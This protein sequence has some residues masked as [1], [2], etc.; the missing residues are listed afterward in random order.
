L[1]KLLFSV[2]IIFGTF[3]VYSAVNTH[4]FMWSDTELIVENQSLNP[5]TKKSVLG[6]WRAPVDGIYSPVTY[7]LWAALTPFARDSQTGNLKP[8][9]FHTANLSVHI[10]NSVLVL[11]LLGF[12]F[13]GGFAPFV[14]AALFALHPLQVEPVALISSFAHLWATFFGLVALIA[15]LGYSRAQGAQSWKQKRPIFRYYF[16]TTAYIASILA[17]PAMV[18]LPFIAALLERLL[19][20]K[21]SL[22][23]PAKAVWP[24]MTWVVLG[25]PVAIAAL[26][27]Q[28]TAAISSQVDW[29]FRPMIAG[30][31]LAFYI[32]KLFVPLGIGP[33][34]GRS[35]AFLQQQWWG[36]LSW[37]TPFVLLVV[38]MFW[39]DKSRTWFASGAAIL[40]F[41]L[42]PFLGLVAFES[43]GSSTVANRYAYFALLGPALC[44]SYLVSIPK[45][46]LFPVLSI[47]ALGLLTFAST[48]QIKHW[49]NDTT[50]WKHSLNIN[51]SSPIAHRILADRYRR[52]GDFENARTH[53][54]KV[55]ET[56]TTDPEVHYHL[57]EM[58]RIKGAHDRAIILYQK[59]LELSPTFAKAHFSFGQSLLATKDYKGANAEFLKALAFNPESAATNFYVGQTAIELGKLEEASQYLNAALALA[60]G[61][62][63]IT[64]RSHAYLGLAMHKLGKKELAKTH[65]EKTLGLSPDQ[66]ESHRILANIYFEQGEFPK[67]LTHYQ[68]AVKK[69]T[70]D[71]AML[72]N[73]GKI[74]LENKANNAAL[75]NF[76]MALDFKPNDPEL[77]NYIAISYFN[78]RRFSD[79]TAKFKE[80][81]QLDPQLA[82]AHYY[83]GDI[84]RWSGKKDHAL[85]SYYKVLR[86]DPLHSLAHYR[87]GNHFMKEEKL[88]QAIRHY[89][90]AL[91]KTPKDHRV[92]A[93][94]RRAKGLLE[95]M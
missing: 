34:Y 28:D 79:A 48:R 17:L 60:D 40:F 75:K 86:I 90:A 1:Q 50:L 26:S 93:N 46:P 14:G 6:F 49:E 20:K 7:T 18:V 38:L 3:K 36:Y 55:V 69:I 11:F 78:L 9:V 71:P 47:V 77:I 44:L 15:Y 56:N 12:F 82:D 13:K 83:L 61:K 62:K 39:R 24:A 87:L 29:W 4:D 37:L 10:V 59:T 22:S 94:L 8:E 64:A 91:K 52:N 2:L 41:G 45:R 63:E 33:D 51:P 73:L 85:A 74:Q 31:A 76:E 35:P 32:N 84:A 5:V 80:A 66:P 65:L 21:D 67:A 19:P 43:Q 42:L 81:L 95:S 57:A 58:E 16:A 68:I 54:H 70:D 23:A 25:I 88:K 92:L 27:F 30:D 89:H 53:Y 72:R